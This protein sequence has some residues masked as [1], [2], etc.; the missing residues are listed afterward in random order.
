MTT[1]RSFATRTIERNA[2]VDM[3]APLIPAPRLR[4]AFKV[5]HIEDDPAVATCIARVLRASGCEVASAATRDEAMQ[6]LEVHGFRPDVI[7]T[8][9]Q[10]QLGV[11]GDVVVAEIAA[12]LKFKPPTIMLTGIASQQ[13][14]GAHSFADRI[15][16]KPVDIN[17]LLREIENLVHERR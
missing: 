12:R 9:Y 7:L 17:V 13:V 8:D 3:P 1:A 16:A 6:H 14:A 4:A 11:T 2:S 10:L 5:L 15:L